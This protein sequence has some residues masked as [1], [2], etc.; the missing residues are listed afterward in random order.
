MKHNIDDIRDSTQMTLQ[1]PLSIL[2]I[3]FKFFKDAIAKTFVTLGQ[4]VRPSSEING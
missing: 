3:L 1:D 4:F 2:N